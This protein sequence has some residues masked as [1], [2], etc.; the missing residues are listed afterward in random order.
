[1]EEEEEEEEEETNRLI[2]SEVRVSRQNGRR[3]ALDNQVCRPVNGR[4]RISNGR[5]GTKKTH[6]PRDSYAR[7]HSQGHYQCTTAHALTPY[8]ST[9]VLPHQSSL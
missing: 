6:K 7:D 9:H 5:L 3:N 2:R 1:M 8:S 4:E